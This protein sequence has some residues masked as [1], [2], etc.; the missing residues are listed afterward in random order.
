MDSIV[1]NIGGRYVDVFA[2]HLVSLFCDAYEVADD[3]TKGMMRH[4]L[5]TWDTCF[6][7][8]KV[9]PIQ[10]AVAQFFSNLITFQLAPC[11]TFQ[12]ESADS[13]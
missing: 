11:H 10:F 12:F 13:K 5:D 3:R 9:L 6:P 2:Q 7:P 8:Q 4:L 1:K